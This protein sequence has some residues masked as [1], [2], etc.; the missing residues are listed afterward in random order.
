MAESEATNI[1]AGSQTQARP[2]GLW[3]ATALVVP[4]GWLV[5]VC[6]V[7]WV[8]ARARRTRGF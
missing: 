1:D 5:P 4:F 3:M 7:A 2:L 8:Q 6:R